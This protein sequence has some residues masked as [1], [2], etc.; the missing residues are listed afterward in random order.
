MGESLF[1]M[2]LV[3]IEKTVIIAFTA[4]YVTKL[5]KRAKLLEFSRNTNL[6]KS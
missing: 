4:L 3:Q 2:T 1:S 5:P 6:G